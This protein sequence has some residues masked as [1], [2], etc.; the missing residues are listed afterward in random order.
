MVNKVDPSTIILNRSAWYL[1]N[2]LLHVI[3]KESIGTFIVYTISNNIKNQ[4]TVGNHL[5]LSFPEVYF[6][7]SNYKRLPRGYCQM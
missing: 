2:M 4:I 1:A 7:L 3:R 6:I 5:A